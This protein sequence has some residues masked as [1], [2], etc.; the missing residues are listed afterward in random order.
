MDQLVEKLLHSP[1]MEIY[2]EQINEARRKEQ[3]A[4]ERFLDQTTE[5]QKAEFINGEI[6]VHSPVRYEANEARRRLSRLA[7]TF[8]DIHRLGRLSDEKLLISLTRNDYEPDISYW[9]S[10]KSSAFEPK[11]LRFP[12]PDWIAEVLSP[13]TESIDRGVKFEDY[14]AH[15]VAEYWIVDADKQIVEQY[16]LIDG[17]YQLLLKSGSGTI[18]SEVITGFEIPIIAIFDDAENLRVLRTLLV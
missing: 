12:A 13:S 9:R 11:Q 4:R 6:V 1:K 3:A 17:N 8:V 15:G 16:T 7:S 18:R 2:L 5:D 14:A 10:E